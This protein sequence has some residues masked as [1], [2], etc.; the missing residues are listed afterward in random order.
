MFL[1]VTLVMDNLLHQL[2]LAEMRAELYVFPTGLDQ[3]YAPDS[4]F[5]R[6]VTRTNTA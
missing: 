6:Q 3:A 4:K 1:Y 5:A 2:N